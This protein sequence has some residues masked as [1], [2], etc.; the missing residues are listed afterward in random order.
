ME[1]RLRSRGSIESGLASRTAPFNGAAAAKPRKP[2]NQQSRRA[3]SGEP[4]QWSRGCEAAEASGWPC[5]RPGHRRSFNGAAAAK[6]RKHDGSWTRR[7]FLRTGPFNGAA[8]AKPRKLGQ[9][10]VGS[11]RWYCRP[12]MEPRLRSRGSGQDT[13]ASDALESQVSVTFN[14]AAAAKPRKRGD[15]QRDGRPIAHGVLQWSRGCEAAEATSS[16]FMRS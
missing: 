8:A 4:L 11:L 1:P 14:G 9:R 16:A 15:R 2:S 7:G 3:S 6:P 10:D 12:S 13:D 5:R